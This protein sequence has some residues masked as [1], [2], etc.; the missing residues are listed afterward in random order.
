M[1][2]TINAI[3]FD[4]DKKLILFVQNKV[5]KLTRFFDDIL[6]AEVFLK[7]ENTQDIDNKTVE[8]KID[9][10]GN[11]L[12][13][14]KQSKAFEESTDLAADA[15]KLQLIKHKEKMRGL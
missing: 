4:A 10:P 11:S 14:R 3:K 7:I 13:S 1:K 8:I 2:I 6:A 5:K 12:F 9:I 15:L